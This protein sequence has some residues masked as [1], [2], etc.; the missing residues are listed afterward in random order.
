LIPEAQKDF[1]AGREGRGDRACK[2]AVDW[3]EK[4]KYEYSRMG[5]IIYSFSALF[6]GSYRVMMRKIFSH[7]QAVNI[8]LLMTRH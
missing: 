7:L 8:L 1:S 5:K 3:L 2:A 6:Y 4:I